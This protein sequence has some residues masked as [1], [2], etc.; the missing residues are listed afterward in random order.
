MLVAV[1]GI[2]K[3]YHGNIMNLLPLVNIISSGISIHMWL[4]KL[5]AFLREDEKINCPAL[6]DMEG[7]MFSKAAINSVFHPITEEINI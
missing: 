1:M 5:V 7:Y 4:E 3:R 6:C 2:F